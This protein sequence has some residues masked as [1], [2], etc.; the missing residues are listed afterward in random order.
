MSMPE[1]LVNV[2]GI[3]L[4]IDILVVNTM[5]NRP[6]QDRGLIRNRVHQGKEETNEE[7]S[8]VS[9]VS[10]ETVDA[11]GDTH[12]A[13][14]EICQQDRDGPLDALIP[15][16][17][18]RNHDCTP[19]REHVTKSNEASSDLT[20]SRHGARRTW[21]LTIWLGQD[22]RRSLGL[23]VNDL[24]V[25]DVVVVIAHG[26]VVRDHVTWGSCNGFLRHCS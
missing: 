4:S 5:I 18:L 24:A 14:K 19:E 17:E 2:V 20:I 3:G 22:D 21:A 25:L 1:A 9:A 10:P 26:Q 6:C 15:C 7:V 16:G 11:C 8:L 12:G 13:R 23:S